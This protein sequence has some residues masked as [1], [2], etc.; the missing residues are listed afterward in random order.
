MFTR[1]LE[2]QMLFSYIFRMFLEEIRVL[3]SRFDST[4]LE[5]L[6]E[7]C[8]HPVDPMDELHRKRRMFLKAHSAKVTKEQRNE[9]NKKRQQ[10]LFSTGE[11][12]M[13]VSKG[14]GSVWSEAW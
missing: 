5:E 6:K 10:V 7:F 2:E 13:S 8:S 11:R 14:T 3:R 4:T 1:V 12:E 9:R